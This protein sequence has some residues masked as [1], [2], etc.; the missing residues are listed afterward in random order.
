[1]NA[2]P[3]L[4]RPSSLPISASAALAAFIAIGLAG[5]DRVDGILVPDGTQLDTTFTLPATRT[6]PSRHW[7]ALGVEPGKTY[8]VEAADVRGDLTANA[9]G[10]L[11]VFGTHPLL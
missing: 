4:P 5:C 11:S 7:F 8:V 3:N 6:L 10:T 9:I 1:M 2:K